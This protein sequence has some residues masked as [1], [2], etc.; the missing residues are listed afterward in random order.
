MHTLN[1]LLSQSFERKAHCR[2]VRPFPLPRRRARG[3]VWDDR[4]KKAHAGTA[5]EAHEEAPRRDPLAKPCSKQQ[6][7]LAS[8]QADGKTNERS[9]KTSWS[10]HKYEQLPSWLANQADITRSAAQLD[11]LLHQANKE[12]G[13][14]NATEEGRANAKRARSAGAGLWPGTLPKRELMGR[15]GCF[16]VQNL[17]DPADC[18]TLLKEAQGQFG[19]GWLHSKVQ[20][21]GRKRSLRSLH[22][23]AVHAGSSGGEATLRSLAWAKLQDELSAEASKAWESAVEAVARR[24]GHDATL[25]SD[26][27]LTLCA[28]GMAEQEL[29]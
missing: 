3:E 19:S 27:A 18:E 23:V 12:L 2:S 1:A 4:S 5:E 10:V 14:G 9:F 22:G 16:V 20:K 6:F 11:E 17:V 8:L 21:R 7:R 26:E 28:E 13:H 29:G 25:S 15:P 24:A